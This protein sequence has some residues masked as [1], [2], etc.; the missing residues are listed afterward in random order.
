M[1]NQ[2]FDESWDTSLVSEMRDGT[3][4]T[5]SETVERLVG[6][7]SDDSYESGSHIDYF[8][9]PVSDTIPKN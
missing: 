4:L 6:I 5:P 1:R 3:S 2:I 8:N 9:V 7:L